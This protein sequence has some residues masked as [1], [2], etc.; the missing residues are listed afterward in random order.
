MPP[1][2]R[3]VMR[4]AKC[5]AGAFS[6][7]LFLLV[8]TLAAVPSFH[9]WVHPDAADPN[10]ECAVTLFLHGQVHGSTTELEASPCP[11]VFV[12]LAPSCGVDFVSTDVR[13][14]PSRGPP[15]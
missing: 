10:H 6:L 7:G 14:L 13:L 15:A 1:S 5:G 9:A 11:P 2:A 4:A 3:K 12:S 8:Q